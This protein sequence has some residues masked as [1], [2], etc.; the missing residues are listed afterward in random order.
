MRPLKR[1]DT[2]KRKKHQTTI[3]FRNTLIV[4]GSLSGRSHLCSFVRDRSPGTSILAVELPGLRS[5]IC[6]SLAHKTLTTTLQMNIKTHKCPVEFRNIHAAGRN[7]FLGLSTLVGNILRARLDS[8]EHILVNST[9]FVRKIQTLD[10][11][12][13]DRLAR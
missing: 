4:A 11:H 12:S 6:S 7:I 3:L 10:V 13:S 9:Q 8:F 2:S 1:F 5:A